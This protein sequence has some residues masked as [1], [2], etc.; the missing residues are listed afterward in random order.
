MSNVLKF[1]VE[2]ET[3]RPTPGIQ[4]ATMNDVLSAPENTTI[5]A[6]V[7]QERRRFR[8]KLVSVEQG[9]PRIAVPIGWRGRPIPVTELVEP[10][11]ETG[12]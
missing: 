4:T 10:K 9:N 3:L 7:G 1:S 12:P 2:A 6:R 5:S 11:I 8:V